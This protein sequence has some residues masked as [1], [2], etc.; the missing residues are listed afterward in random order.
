MVWYKPAIF[1]S[2]AGIPSG[3]PKF[4]LIAAD[5]AT[6]VPCPVENDVRARQNGDLSKQK[7]GLGVIFQQKYLE[8]RSRKVG[9]SYS[10]YGGGI[11]LGP[12]LSNY[13]KIS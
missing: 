8:N 6:D 2:S 4:S 9:H 7:W 5:A 3:K 11:T 13:W 10:T 12:Q 1:G